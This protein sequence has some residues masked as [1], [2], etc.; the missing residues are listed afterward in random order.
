MG[1]PLCAIQTFN[2]STASEHQMNLDVVPLNLDQSIKLLLEGLP[3]ED[4]AAIQRSPN[5][6]FALAGTYHSL[7]EWLRLNWSLNSPTPLVQWFSEVGI[8][9]PDD[10]ICTIIK[11][12]YLKLNGLT[13]DL[14]E[15]VEITRANQAIEHK[16]GS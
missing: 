1:G 5:P 14:N 12:L 7:G 4:L 13:I 10:M 11:A 16:T 9:H 3:T 15:E 8:A 6:A 2:T